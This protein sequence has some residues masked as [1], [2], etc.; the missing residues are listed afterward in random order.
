MSISKPI[1]T[2]QPVGAPPIL[3]SSSG[4]S[5]RFVANTGPDGLAGA[6]RRLSDFEFEISNFLRD[7]G[8]AGKAFRRTAFIPFYEEVG[9]QE[10]DVWLTEHILEELGAL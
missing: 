1:R 10:L 5:W 9:K 4:Q 2:L 8:P 6:V 3:S 7:V